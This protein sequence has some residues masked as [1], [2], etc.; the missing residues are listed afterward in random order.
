MSNQ[1]SSVATLKGIPTEH[2]L[3]QMLQEQILKVTFVKLDGDQRVMTC[4]NVWDLIP[5]SKRPTIARSNKQG[6]VT[7]W[8]L[9]ADDWRSFRYD[10]L[11]AVESCDPTPRLVQTVDTETK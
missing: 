10:R 11:Q 5:E 8:D 3:S 2:D 9:T 6:T 1:E 7:V 4:T